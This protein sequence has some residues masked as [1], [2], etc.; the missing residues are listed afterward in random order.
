MIE[1]LGDDLESLVARKEVKLSVGTR[2]YISRL[3]AE[4]R[5]KEAMQIAQQKREQKAQRREEKARVEL[6]RSLLELL[7]TPDPE[8][9]AEKEIEV[10][11]LLDATGQINPKERVTELEGTLATMDPHIRKLIEPRLGEI[12]DGLKPLMSESRFPRR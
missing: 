6:N 1:R 10:I 3:K 2:R 11:W 5:W 7:T 4:G 12:R 8:I 9:E